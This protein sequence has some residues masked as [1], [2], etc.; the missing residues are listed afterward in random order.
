[1]NIGTFHAMHRRQKAKADVCGKS[2]V[3]CIKKGTGWER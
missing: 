3:N 1:M 2:A